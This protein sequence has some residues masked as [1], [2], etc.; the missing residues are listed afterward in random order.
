MAASTGEPVGNA[1]GH[2]AGSK[3]VAVVGGGLVRK[4]INYWQNG[5]FHNFVG[6]LC[7]MI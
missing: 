5:A 7:D 4:L 3:R 2:L 6:F 1:K